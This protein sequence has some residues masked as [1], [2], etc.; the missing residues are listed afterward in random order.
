MTK[1]TGKAQSAAAPD[2]QARAARDLRGPIHTLAG[3]LDLLAHSALDDEQRRY[4]ALSH[5]ALTSLRDVVDEHLD[6]RTA[7]APTAPMTEMTTTTTPDRGPRVL[8]VDDDEP[9]LLYACA[10]L[11]EAGAVVV[12]ER[13][14]ERVLSV[15]AARGP[16]SLVLVDLQMP[17]I[18]GLELLR[19]LTL[20]P[21][22]ASTSLVV[23][24]GVSDPAAQ[25]AAIDAGAVACVLKPA[26]PSTLVAVLH[27]HSD[28]AHN[29]FA[30][31][32]AAVVAAIAADD[33]RALALVV[34]AIR[35][36]HPQ[37]AQRLEGRLGRRELPGILADLDTAINAA[38]AVPINDVPPAVALAATTLFR[39]SAQRERERLQAL[40]TSTMRALPASTRPSSASASMSA[41]TMTPMTAPLRLLLKQMAHRLAGSASTFG[42]V[43]IGEVAR[44]VSI[45]MASNVS[46]DDLL[47]YAQ[48]LLAALH[49]VLPPVR[50]DEPQTSGTS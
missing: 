45:A 26:S 8:V 13:R 42:H 49:T 17:G 39:A 28:P 21:A 46:D 12:V 30:V 10:V 38:P 7:D 6:T 44:A 36:R 2:S 48:Q 14:A 11:Q 18:G 15:I 33:V 3:L 32:R 22:M 31:R 25:Q 47:A 5:E 41:A 20:A 23:L 1:T 34:G 37:L 50:A 35:V 43:Y 27:R 19:Q 16:F 9:S 4:L 24:S 29:E 40:L